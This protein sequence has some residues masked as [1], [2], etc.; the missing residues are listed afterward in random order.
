[1]PG[2]VAALR[3]LGVDPDGR[4]LRRDPLLRRE[5][6]GRGALLGRAGLGVRRTD[7]ARRAVRRGGRRAG[8]T[9]TTATVDAI[10]QTRQPRDAAGLSGALPGRP[11]TACTRPCAALV[12]LDAADP[13]GRGARA[14]GSACA[15][16]S[17]STP[18]T[19]LVEVHW[20]ATCEAYVT[21]VGDDLVGV[22]VLTS[23]REP[24][25]RQL[26][27]FPALAERLET[28]RAAGATSGAR[29]AG[30]LRQRSRPGWPG[31]CCW[32]ATR[33]ATSTR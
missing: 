16:T 19:D 25:R 28:A 6:A 33:P 23:R 30:P 5:P 29:G 7:A 31:G 20:A 12:G 1:M 24:V 22:A 26:A 8:S 17:R 2:A 32:S 11:P 27:G 9:C 4:R 18:W 21:P 10:E 15:G 14:P 13:A 3:R